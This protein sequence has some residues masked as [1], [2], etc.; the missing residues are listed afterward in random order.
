MLTPEQ[1]TCHQQFSEENLDML[2]ASPGNFFSRIIPGDETWVHIRD[3]ETKQESMQ[4]KYKGS[5][6]PKKFYVQQLARKIMATVFWNSESVLLLE[7]MLH[8]TITRDT[9]ASI[10]VA[11]RENIKT[12]TPWKVVGWC[13]GAS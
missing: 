3:P 13:P 5:P 6:T 9:Y 2:R 11:L 8:K 12:K 4:W 10:M 1:K 7:L